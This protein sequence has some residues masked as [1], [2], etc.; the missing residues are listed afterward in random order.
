MHR[1]RSQGENAEVFVLD[2]L[3]HRM[4]EIADYNSGANGCCSAKLLSVK[5]AVAATLFVLLATC[6]AT[7]QTQAS[8]ANY[9]TYR[10]GG[11]VKAPRPISTSTPAP[12]AGVDK[13]LEVRLS[14]IVIPDGSVANVRLLKH[15]TPEF[16]DFAVAVVSKWRFEPATKDG[17]PVAV[18]LETEMQSH[19]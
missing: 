15:S 13:T 4:S 11:D 6:F 12:P 2:I 3:S 19:K 5:T 10:V 1:S 18:R 9:P 14:F 7:G 8:N 17:R 16:D